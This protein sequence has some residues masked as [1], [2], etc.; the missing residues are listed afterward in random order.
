MVYANGA[1]GVSVP[2]ESARRRPSVPIKVSP[3][4]KHPPFGS[5]S[6]LAFWLGRPTYAR[7]TRTR[8]RRARP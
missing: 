1:H 8:A 3:C 6:A 7:P 5:M 2:V 4:R